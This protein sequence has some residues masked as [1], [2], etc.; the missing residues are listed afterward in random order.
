VDVAAAVLAHL[1]SVAHGLGASLVCALCLYIAGLALLPT[2]SRLTEGEFPGLLGA[3]VFVMLCWFGIASNISVS[4]LATVFPVA[5][6]ALALVRR[7]AV[8]GSAR[9]AFGREAAGWFAVF[10]FLYIIGYAFTL[11][12]AT[13]S[14]LPPAWTGNIDLVSYVRNAKYLLRLGPSNL[15]GWSYLG[16]VYLQTPGAFYLL[17]AL[18]M[19]FAQDP[20]RASMPAQFAF[21]ALIGVLAARISRQVFLVSRGAAAAIAGILVSGTFFRYV[22][23][24]YFLSTLMSLPVVLFLLWTTISSKPQRW[25]DAATAVKFGCC[26]LL[27]LQ[28][29]PFLL[30]V[31]LGVQAAAIAFMFLAELQSTGGVG[32]R[33]AWAAALRST[34]K[35][36]ALAVAAIVVLAAAFYERVIWSATMILGLSE[37]DAAGW[38]LDIIA[39]AA[40][41]GFP[42][43]SIAGADIQVADPSA[44]PW[45]VAIF[46]AIGV[47]LLLLYFWWFRQRTSPEARSMAGVTGTAFLAYMAYFSLIG[48]SYQQW[49]FASYSALPLSFVVFAGGLQLAQRARILS[50]LT[51]TT[52]GRRVAVSLLT[53]CGVVMIAGNFIVHATE[54]PYLVRI[55]GEVRKIETLNELTSFRELSLW[56]ERYDVAFWLSVY[57]LPSKRVSVFGSDYKFDEWLF[58]EISRTKPL[59][60]LGKGC[61]DAGH[62]ETVEVPD[63]GCLLFAPPTAALNATYELNQT[64]LFIASEG[65]SGTEPAGRWNQRKEVRLKVHA[66]PQ[67][68]SLT[69]RLYINL[70][71]APFLPAG[72]TRQRMNLSWGDDHG[73]QVVIQDDEWLSLAVQSRDWRGNWVWTVPIGIELPDAIAGALVG[74]SDAPYVEDRPLAIRFVQL[75]ITAAPKGRVI[76]QVKQ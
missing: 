14:H 72:V 60:A 28:I 33:Q 54:D 26:Y 18:S 39:P 21:T 53:V 43:R 58:E 73:A 29:Y 52:L 24:A 37:K 36:A 31:G 41:L 38:P 12:P 51:R 50:P 64:H 40:L 4:R 62:D 68:V 17:D 19:L 65:L 46:C 15:A 7:R 10:A 11:P 3:T 5:V 27:L 9:A 45:A 57:Y 69:D 74:S 20:L 66:D 63:V 2:R 48:P 71:V 13:L 47:A 25:L 49:K 70:H 16:D 6:V 44:R 34:A 23:G 56:S 75:S 1:V 59:L 61:G 35:R 32:T 67:R 30:A 22:A 42:G 55:P 8:S 76:E